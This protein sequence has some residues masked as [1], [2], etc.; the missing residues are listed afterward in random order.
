[1]FIRTAGYNLRCRWCDTPHTSWTVVGEHLEVGRV[2]EQTNIWRN[3]EH[4]V[5]TGGEPLIQKDLAELVAGLRERDHFVTWRR[6]ARVTT[7]APIPSSLASPQNC[8]TV[9]PTTVTPSN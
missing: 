7:A 8:S 1:M 6:R 2:L 3:V 4:V 5:V 9:I